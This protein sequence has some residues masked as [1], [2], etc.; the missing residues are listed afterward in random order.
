PAPRLAERAR[1]VAPRPGPRRIAHRA[2]GADRLLAED[3]LRLRGRQGRFLL[4]IQKQPAVVSFAQVSYRPLHTYRFVNATRS[5][6]DGCAWGRSCFGSSWNS[7]RKGT[8]RLGVWHC[9]TAPARVVRDPCRRTPRSAA[10]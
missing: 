4:L 2:G 7:P 3:A 9:Y 1:P 6:S 8:R 10:R 5:S